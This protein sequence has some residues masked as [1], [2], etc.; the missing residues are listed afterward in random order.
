MTNLDNTLMLMT[1]RV[2]ERWFCSFYGLKLNS[3]LEK[4]YIVEVV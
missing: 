4:P 2:G 1:C 3:D